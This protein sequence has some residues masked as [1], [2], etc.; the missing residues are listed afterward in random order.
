MF[1]G[2]GFVFQISEN[3]SVSCGIPILGCETDGIDIPGSAGI[4]IVMVVVFTGEVAMRRTA[5]RS[6]RLYLENPWNKFDFI[7]VS[8]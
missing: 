5:A 2:F 1:W 7:V 8:K 4:S 6:W 3:S